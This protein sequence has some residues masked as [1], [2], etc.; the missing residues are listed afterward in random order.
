MKNTF[1][2]F[3]ES[4]IV[5]FSEEMA[6]RFDFTRCQRPNGTFYGTGG[7]CRKGAQVGPKEIAALKKAAAGG[8]ERAQKA[9]DK[10]EG[11]DSKPVAKEEAPKK[12]AI[13]AAEKMTFEQIA[14]VPEG[15]R[16]DTSDG[17]VYQMVDGK[18]YRVKEDDS[19]GSLDYKPGELLQQAKYTA[20][21]NPRPE[22]AKPKDDGV[23]TRD[24]KDTKAAKSEE[25]PYKKG[26]FAPEKDAWKD[27]AKLEAA[28]AAWRERQGL[29]D[30]TSVHDLVHMGVHSFTGRTSEDLAKM[31]GQKGV[32][33]TEEILVNLVS[34]HAAGGGGKID[35]R[36]SLLAEAKEMRNFFE[37]GEGLTPLQIRR[38]DRDS[39]R[40][41]AIFERM[42]KQEGFDDFI[43]QMEGYAG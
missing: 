42:S 17:T 23:K 24:E 9:L 21:T 11:K 16:V 32:T 28:A 2:K 7:Q 5:D 18:F 15:G 29:A 26:E 30:E 10:V 27:D 43:S 19:L 3:S 22:E 14:D 40:A 4:A 31:Q 1:G 20:K 33:T 39:R 35:N 6:E 36:S 12:A 41:V 8:N 34:F 37:E 25:G 38:W 13:G